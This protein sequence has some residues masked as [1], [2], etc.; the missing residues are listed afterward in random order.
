[1]G[2]VYT[3]VN[4][5]SKNG[6]PTRL[7]YLRRP[8]IQKHFSGNVCATSI[9][10]RVSEQQWVSRRFC[11]RLECYSRVVK[12]GAR[13]FLVGRRVPCSTDV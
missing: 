11:K 10:E 8:V 7:G 6:I 3:N 1:M 13:M 5:R 2:R 4:F 12:G 9:V